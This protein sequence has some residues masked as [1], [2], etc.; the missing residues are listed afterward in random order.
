MKFKRFLLR[1]PLAAMSSSSELWSTAVT[2]PWGTRCARLIPGSPVPL[3]R[4]RTRMPGVGHEYSTNASVTA[5]PSTADFAFHFSAAI[6]RKEE[7][8]GAG[9]EADTSGLLFACQRGRSGNG[10]GGRGSGRPGFG[11]DGPSRLRFRYQFRR[12]QPLG[13]LPQAFQVVE[14]ARFL[15]EDMDD[16]VHVV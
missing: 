14:L 10:F 16:K 11:R 2:E 13:R 12:L 5:L 4:S 7:P 9:L 3:A 15:G 1:A 6:R 8:H